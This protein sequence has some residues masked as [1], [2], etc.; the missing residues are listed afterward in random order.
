MEPFVSHMDLA[1]HIDDDDPKKWGRG[2]FRGQG[3]LGILALQRN[4]FN[5]RHT[6][7]HPLNRSLTKVAG[8][9]VV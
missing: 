3:A 1:M 6:P 9:V 4:T 5:V 2:P 7:P 8:S